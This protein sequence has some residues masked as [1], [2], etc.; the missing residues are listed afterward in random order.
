M[1]NDFSSIGLQPSDIVTRPRVGVSLSVAIEP[2]KI[3]SLKVSD[4]N[5]KGTP[6]RENIFY[7]IKRH[8]VFVVLTG[9]ILLALLYG[10][11]TIYK[12]PVRNSPDSF[13]ISW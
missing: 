7:K 1:R 8:S 13:Y 10:V 9:A 6:T 11:F 2:I 12:A 5:V 3:T 4:E